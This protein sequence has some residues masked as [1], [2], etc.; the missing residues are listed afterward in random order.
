MR[1]C[2]VALCCVAGRG[3]GREEAQ[4]GEGRGGD[5]ALCG[6][7][8]GGALST[9]AQQ[10]GQS[11]LGLADSGLGFNLAQEP[12][13]HDACSRLMDGPSRFH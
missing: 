8:C 9:P 2:P 6:A 1:V 5:S 12:A 10:E 7:L 11:M 4:G 3:R 13:R